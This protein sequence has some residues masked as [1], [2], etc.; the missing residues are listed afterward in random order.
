MR[1]NSGHTP[2]ALITEVESGPGVKALLDCH[3]LVLGAQFSEPIP[4]KGEE[5]GSGSWQ[6]AHPSEEF[7]LDEFCKR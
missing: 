1:D 6:Q 5:K 4:I 3:T 2:L 7:P